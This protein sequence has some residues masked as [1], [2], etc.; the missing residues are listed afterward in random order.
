MKE[1]DSDGRA[2]ERK[3]G[4]WGGGGSREGERESAIETGPSFLSPPGERQVLGLV[5]HTVGCAD[6]TF[7]PVAV[8]KNCSA[9]RRDEY[10]YA[11]NTSEP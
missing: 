6:R 1:K 7:F 9:R 5:L 11:L 4:G 2:I 8:I 10:V 3:R